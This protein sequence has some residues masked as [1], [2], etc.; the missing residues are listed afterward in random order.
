ML[1][2]QVVYILLNKIDDMGDIFFK[3]NK[4][5]LLFRSVFFSSSP[6]KHEHMSEERL[7]E[8]VDQ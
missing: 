6:Y 3:E 2:V 1:N 4:S 8:Y 5:S 7:D